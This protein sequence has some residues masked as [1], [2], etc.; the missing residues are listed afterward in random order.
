[1]EEKFIVNKGKSDKGTVLIRTITDQNTG[2]Q[3]LYIYDSMY[4][5]TVLTPLLT[6][7]GKPLINN[8]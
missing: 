6:T 1:M 5:A 3:Y 7:D 8:A 4:G 2:V